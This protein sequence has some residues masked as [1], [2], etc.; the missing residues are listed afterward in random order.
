MFSGSPTRS[1][2][3]PPAGR[4]VCQFTDL[5]WTKFFDC[6]AKCRNKGKKIGQPVGLGPENN[7]SKGRFLSRCLFRQTL[8]DR[9][10]DIEAPSHG[11]QQGAIMEITPTHFLHRFDLVRR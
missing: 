5:T 3:A 2:L 9:D 6:K 8:V 1:F 11:I 7:N 4:S 10:Q